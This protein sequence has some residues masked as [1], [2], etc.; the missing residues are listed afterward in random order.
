MSELKKIMFGFVLLAIGFY[1]FLDLKSNAMPD[2]IKL[3]FEEKKRKYP[4]VTDKNRH[5]ILEELKIEFTYDVPFLREVSEQIVAGE[6]GFGRAKDLE[7]AIMRAAMAAFGQ[8]IPSELNGSLFGLKSFIRDSLKQCLEWVV[9]TQDLLEIQK[10][11]LTEEEVQKALRYVNS[12]FFKYFLGGPL[13]SQIRPNRYS[14]RKYFDRFDQ[15]T[16][17]ANGARLFSD[18]SSFGLGVPSI[19]ISFGLASAAIAI[20]TIAFVPIS[21]TFF[22]IGLASIATY[23]SVIFAQNRI[24][25][26]LDVLSERLESKIYFLDLKK[27]DYTPLEESMFF[28]G[29]AISR[30]RNIKKNKTLVVYNGISEVVKSILNRI[31]ASSNKAEELEKF[32][33]MVELMKNPPN[34]L[35]KDTIARSKKQFSKLV[36]SVINSRKY[37]NVGDYQTYLAVMRALGI[38]PMKPGLMPMAIEFIIKK[39]SLRKT[40]QEKFEANNLAQ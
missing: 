3:F 16:V 14:E 21:A 18:V 33:L 25:K 38:Q 28:H 40:I 30:L 17:A 22:A 24:F 6:I 19:L 13:K 27:T 35:S 39:N 11:A 10:M 34:Y 8:I 15:W 29:L 32:Y 2:R 26:L 9:T 4:N 23:Y 12:S 20:P 31:N 1:Y 7:G 37:L 5:T 36:F